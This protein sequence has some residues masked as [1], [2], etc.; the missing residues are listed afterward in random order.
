MKTIRNLVLTGALAALGACA[1]QNCMNVQEV[2]SKIP[3]AVIYSNPQIRYNENL[4]VV[5][6]ENDF[7]KPSKRVFMRIGKISS[8]GYS[9]AQFDSG[10]A[11]YD[12]R[13]DAEFQI[14]IYL[15]KDVATPE[16]LGNAIYCPHVREITLNDKGQRKYAAEVSCSLEPELLP[17]NVRENVKMNIGR[18]NLK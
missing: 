13:R 7:S 8:I 5:R 12:A 11:R 18:L 17:E 15:D 6:D 10:Y 1:G 14:R 3:K 9:G 16:V 2:K 4:E